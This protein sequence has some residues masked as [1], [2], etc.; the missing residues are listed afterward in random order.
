MKKH[1]AFLVAATCAAACSSSKADK[2]KGSP[3]W[4]DDPR[5][6]GACVATVKAGVDAPAG[7]RSY[8]LE[9]QTKAE[10]TAPS[11]KIDYV[12]GEHE[13]CASRGFAKKCEGTEF[14]SSTRF[15]E[16]PTAQVSPNVEVGKQAVAIMQAGAKAADEIKD[17]TALGN[18]LDELRTPLWE[19][20][21]AHPGLF[22]KMTDGE[23]KQVHAA[24][25]MEAL[26]E[27]L[28]RC[29]DNAHAKEFMYA[30]TKLMD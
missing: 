20:G 15:K 28:P 14:P 29:K 19:L 21:K 30:I 2:P 13:T 9:N 7:P 27:R 25:A 6:L 22:R 18:K 12:Y 5:P 17:C 3:D 26:A 24:D 1:L 23:L 11:D 16:C 4:G 10:C 8:C